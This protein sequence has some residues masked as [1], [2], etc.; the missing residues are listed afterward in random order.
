MILQVMNILW[1]SM[2]QVRLSAAGPA[3][4]QLH[5]SSAIA[6]DTVVNCEISHATLHNQLT[7]QQKIIEATCLELQSAAGNSH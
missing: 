2:C 1:G 4:N 6:L 5:H 3:R 7:L